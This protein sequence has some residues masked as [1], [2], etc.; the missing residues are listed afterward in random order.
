M[1]RSI[2]GIC[3]CMSVRTRLVAL[4]PA[5]PRSATGPALDVGS[6]ASLDDPAPACVGCVGA[7]VAG[8]CTRCPSMCTPGLSAPLG[9]LPGSPCA[10]WAGRPMVLGAGGGGMVGMG[11]S[12]RLLLFD[13]AV[14]KGCTDTSFIVTRLCCD[15]SAPSWCSL[16]GTGL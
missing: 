9:R 2:S 11:T 7:G 14:H 10:D 16:Q 15:N 8:A 6:P 5:L 12:A 4:T 3:I 1:C 13:S